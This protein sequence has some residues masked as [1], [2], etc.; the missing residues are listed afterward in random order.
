MSFDMPSGLRFRLQTVII[1]VVVFFTLDIKYLYDTTLRVGGGV[2]HPLNGDS[3]AHFI[4]GS[5]AIIV[6]EPRGV[7]LK[8]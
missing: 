2:S 1:I 7:Q 4:A 5:Y 3:L 8:G 6:A